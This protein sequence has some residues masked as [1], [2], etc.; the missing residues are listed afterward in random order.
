M[1]TIRRGGSGCPGGGAEPP[2]WPA[3]FQERQRQADAGGP[4][5]ATAGRA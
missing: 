5:E 3:R 2:D 1:A 4:E